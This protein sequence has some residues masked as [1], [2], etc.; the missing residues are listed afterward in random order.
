M[1]DAFRNSPSPLPQH[2]YGVYD[3]Y[4]YTRRSALRL[5]D[6]QI[7]GGNRQAAEQGG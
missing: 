2:G 3:R 1:N 5:R 4:R 7:A 6:G